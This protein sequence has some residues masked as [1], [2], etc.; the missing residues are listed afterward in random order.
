MPVTGGMPEAQN[1]A[2]KV[3]EMVLNN[4]LREEK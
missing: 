1:N 3:R 4:K 2:P